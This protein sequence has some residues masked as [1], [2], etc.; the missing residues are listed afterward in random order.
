MWSYPRTPKK[1]DDK[2]AEGLKSREAELFQRLLSSTW[3][4]SELADNLQVR[5]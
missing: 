1:E 2:E 5:T 4:G 3:E